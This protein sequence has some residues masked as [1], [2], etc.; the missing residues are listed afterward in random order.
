M[1][2]KCFLGRLKCGVKMSK[3]MLL[4]WCFG[5]KCRKLGRHFLRLSDNLEGLNDAKCSSAIVFLRENGV[6]KVAYDD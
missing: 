5:A 6:R 4:G 1:G 2:H 3:M